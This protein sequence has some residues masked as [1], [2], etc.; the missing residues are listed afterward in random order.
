MEN[1]ARLGNS[2]RR[3]IW[4]LVGE[5]QQTIRFC[6]EWLEIKDPRIHQNEA[7]KQSG[8]HLPITGLYKRVYVSLNHA[9][10]KS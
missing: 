1:N 9:R 8:W 4:F 7:A 10:V 3:E 2:C 6:E 5:H